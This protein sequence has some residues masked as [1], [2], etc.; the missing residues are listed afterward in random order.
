MS[1]LNTL[2]ADTSYLGL[3]NVLASLSTDYSQILADIK[4]EQEIVPD[5]IEEDFEG[6]EGS[7]ETI[8]LPS[9]WEEAIYSIG[10]GVTDS[11]H[12]EYIQL[13]FLFVII[14]LSVN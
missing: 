9:Q 13:V 1:S 6:P 11:T 2:K 8:W 12:C 4:E 5:L 7:T 10:K 14:V 3:T